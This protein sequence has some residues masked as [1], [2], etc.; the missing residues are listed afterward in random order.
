MKIYLENAQSLSEGIAILSEDLGI[1]LTAKET[2]ELLIHVHETEER[3]LQ[4]SLDG[5][6]AEISYGDGKARFFRGLATLIHWIEQG[7][8]KKTVTEKPL[9][10]TN[11]TMVDMSRNAVMNV[12]TVKTMLRKIALMGLNT[13]M[14][15]TEDTYEIEEYPYFGYMRGRYTKEEIRE[16]DAYAA[17][18]G[19]EL[20]P[21]IQMLGH[22]ATHLRWDAAKG[23]KDGANTLLV[24]EDATYRLI[25]SMLKTVSECFTTRRIH[26]GMDETMDL[27]RGSYLDKFG[28]RDHQDIYFEHLEKV[29][30]MCQKYGFKPMMWSDMFFRMAGRNIK[31]YSDYHPDVEFTDDV[32]AKIPRG[33]QQVFWDYYNPS[34]AFY[35]VN[36]DKH[37]MLFGEDIL[38]AGGV[39]E[40][41]GHCPI[42][43]RSLTFTIPAL[44]ACRKKGVPEV[45]AT[46]WHNGSESS[47]ILG[48]CGLAW[49][50]DY[51]YRGCYDPDGVKECFEASCRGVS[52]EEIMNCDLPERIDPEN[53]EPLSITRLC[54]YN[55]PMLGM[56][57][58]HLEGCDLRGH[59]ERVTA[60]LK[61]ANGEKDI[62][63][64]AYEVIVLLSSLLEN[65]ADFGVRLK[66]A[67]DAGDREALA[68]LLAECDVIVEKIRAL[69][70]SHRASWMEYNKPF[71]WEVH[72]IRYGG[73]LA[74]FDT[75][76]ERLGAYLAGE[77]DRLEELEESRLRLDGQLGE[78]AQPRFHGRFLW[79]Q[80]GF[81]STA[82]IL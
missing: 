58:R 57:D 49:Y 53:K 50:A 22:L 74:R 12:K 34:E 1:E 29:I 79:T 64:P 54:L 9:F 38:F 3:T 7:E 67:Y 25:D 11:G 21:C 52:Y 14:L 66:A 32:I 60:Q 59:F 39:W 28:Y 71:G 36:I 48:L 2:A 13:Y 42:F 40:W 6:T 69:R 44:E 27:G 43:T 23:Y 46:I 24:G 20:I 75:V 80:Y 55:D 4:V 26:V 10:K 56:V 19:I 45:F 65:K 18:L 37:H 82:G 76:K 8:T 63:A 61:N 72:D 5:K 30:A 15:Y 73:M 70:A 16:L 33:I 31:G 78:D 81:V 41:S 68:A 47:L 51:D 17:V 62:F 77:T 35:A